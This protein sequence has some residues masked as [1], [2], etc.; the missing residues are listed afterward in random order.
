[1]PPCPF[2]LLRPQ[3]LWRQRRPTRGPGGAQAILVE[4][5]AQH[6]LLL[7]EARRVERC[8]ARHRIFGLGLKER[9]WWERR[10]ENG[11]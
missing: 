3:P 8:L 10:V 7:V 1:M 5:G 9:K 4:G 2:R 6:G 11:G